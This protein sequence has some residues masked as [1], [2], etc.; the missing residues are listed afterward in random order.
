MYEKAFEL[1]ENM[2]E[3]MLEEAKPPGP[4]PVVGE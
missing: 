4:R 2:G 3:N 1:G